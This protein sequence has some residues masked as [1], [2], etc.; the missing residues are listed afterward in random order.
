M[1]VPKK[2]GQNKGFGVR[3]ESAGGPPALRHTGHF[4]FAH[5]GHYRA[6]RRK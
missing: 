5:T 3:S 4:N 6:L 2:R 1:Q